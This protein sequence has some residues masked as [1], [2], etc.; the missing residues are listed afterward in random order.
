MTHYS[1]RYKTYTSFRNNF[2][3]KCQNA[4]KYQGYLATT[5]RKCFIQRR[6]HLSTNNTVPLIDMKQIPPLVYIISYNLN[7]YK[8]I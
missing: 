4:S 2:L 1:W 3:I 5:M 8:H 7:I 6:F